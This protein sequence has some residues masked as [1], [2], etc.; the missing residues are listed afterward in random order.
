MTVETIR[1]GMRRHRVNKVFMV[2][3]AGDD[4]ATR[5]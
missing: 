4:A 5:M 1:A 2:R 3:R